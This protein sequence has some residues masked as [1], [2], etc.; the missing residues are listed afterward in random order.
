MDAVVTDAG[1]PWDPNKETRQAI[2]TF[3]REVAACLRED[4]K[5]IQI[6]FQ[7]PHFRKRLM[8][9]PYL[10]LDY[11][12]DIDCGLGYYFYVYRKKTLSHL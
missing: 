4:G 7:Q 1:D 5:L 3:A 2:C 8:D 9:T 11:V 10:E 12:S 6:S